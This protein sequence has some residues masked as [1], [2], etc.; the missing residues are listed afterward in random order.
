MS[1]IKTNTTTAAQKNK[2]PTDSD[3]PTANEMPQLSEMAN[4]PIATSDNERANESPHT[5]TEQTK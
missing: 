4:Q 2:S 5:T 1:R 3:V